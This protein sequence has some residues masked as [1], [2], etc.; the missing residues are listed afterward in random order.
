MKRLRRW[1]M[2]DGLF[3]CKGHARSIRFIKAEMTTA[4]R[5]K[6]SATA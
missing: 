1:M 6:T 2:D 5:E 4:K 3:G